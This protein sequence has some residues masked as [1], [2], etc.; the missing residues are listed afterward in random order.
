MLDANIGWSC[1]PSLTGR[2][3]SDHTRRKTFIGGGM[4]TGRFAPQQHSWRCGRSGML[5]GRVVIAIVATRVM[6][7]RASAAIA[8]AAQNRERLSGV[9]PRNNEQLG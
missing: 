9:T 3:I 7:T 2:L 5:V 4:G 6:L 8:A 1:L